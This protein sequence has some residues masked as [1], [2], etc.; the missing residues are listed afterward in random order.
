MEYHSTDDRA[1][2]AR[3]AD[4]LKALADPWRLMICTY[5]AS[6]EQASVTEI[7]AAVGGNLMG[8]SHHMGLLRNAGYVEF[9]SDGRSRYY[10]LADGVQ[11]MPSDRRDIGGWDL[12]AAVVMLRLPPT[13][14]GQEVPE[15]V[16]PKP[17]AKKKGGKHHA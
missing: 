16:K 4:R 7:A 3:L 12:G 14:P 10:R 5:L 13:D 1:G 15:A 6:V 11:A 17:K 9:S 8:V 2:M